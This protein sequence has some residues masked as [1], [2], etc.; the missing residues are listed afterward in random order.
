MPPTPD[1]D[2]DDNGSDQPGTD[3]GTQPGTATSSDEAPTESDTREAE[4]GPGRDTAEAGVSETDGTSEGEPFPPRGTLTLRALRWAGVVGAVVFGATALL[5]SRE[6][7]EAS[8]AIPDKVST[9]TWCMFFG[10]LM[11]W[12]FFN[13]REKKGPIL[14]TIVT[15][16]MAALGMTASASLTLAWW[17]TYQETGFS[18]LFL[19]A[20]AGAVLAA[21]LFLSA[22]TMLHYLRMRTTATG[23]GDPN[24]PSRWRRL[25]VKTGEKT[26]KGLPRYESVRVPRRTRA[27]FAALIIA[28]A[29]TLG[30]AI[31]GTWAR[32]NPVHHVIAKAPA[33]ASLEPP[34]SLAP[35][36]SWSKEISSTELSIVAGAG[37]PILLTDDGV[38]ALSSKDGSVLWS[39]ER[40]HMTYAPAGWNSSRGELVTSPD[41]KYV[42]ARVQLPTFVASPQAITLVFD[43]LTGRLVFERQGTGGY[44]QLTDSAVLDGDTAFSLTDGSQMW[45][46]PESADAPYSGPAGHSSF[47]LRLSED[48]STKDASSNSM[49]S[50]VNITVCPQ[51]DPSSKVEVQH[52]LSEPPFGPN[53]TDYLLSVFING[54][55]ARYTDKVDSSGNPVAEAISL[56]ALAK[57]DGA[58]TTAFPLGATS[59]INAEASRV[60]GS[61]VTYPV[62]S[63]DTN[64]L[65]P[66][67]G[68]RAATVFDPS[69]RTVTPASQDRSLAAARTGIVEVPAD[70]G[71]TSAA[72]VIRPGDGS[73]GTTIPITPGSTYQPSQ[74]LTDTK[75]A[76]AQPLAPRDVSSTS[77]SK[78]I[79][80]PGAVI[81]IL[82]ATDKLRT[83][84]GVDSGDNDQTC[85]S[86]YR[87]FGIVGGQK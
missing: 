77:R 59:G 66:A 47:I 35:K 1:A 75:N 37:G 39:Y 32:I 10:G 12:P 17:D 7:T 64:I 58:D 62:I 27:Y 11:V 44:L 86:T 79:R 38:M 85:R 18:V 22:G 56:D 71:S 68:S 34:A 54:W 41:G 60:S 63:R 45:S 30:S 9:L 26:D 61:M 65:Y 5:L 76:P 43:A 78:A 31:A 29:L 69:T 72:L 13:F 24:D 83:S 87:I 48:R 20:L 33:D 21:A 74:R 52:V 53:H 19:L 8:S 14:T 80:T 51:N 42:A 57:V 67:E 70:D 40:K 4:V 81:A 55:A 15:T 25:H 82:N 46:L 84:C 73:S 6:L 49:M 23:I 2:T 16:V 36:A 28:P 3:P 50:A